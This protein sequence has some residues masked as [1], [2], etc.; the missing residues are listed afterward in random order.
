MPV[1]GEFVGGGESL[2][3]ALWEDWA[4]ER[5]PMPRRA[6][7][8]GG[9]SAEDSAHHPMAVEAVLTSGAYV[10]PRLARRAPWYCTCGTD[11]KRQPRRWVALTHVTEQEHIS[12]AAVII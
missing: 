4:T 7:E 8:G 9:S 5:E 1:R 10:C 12:C 3:M 6:V 2:A 11:I